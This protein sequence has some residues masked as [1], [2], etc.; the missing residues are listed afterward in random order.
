MAYPVSAGV[1][2]PTAVMGRRIG[3]F[4]IDLVIGLILVLG[5]SRLTVES[6]IFE[7]LNLCEQ[8]GSSELFGGDREDTD[9]TSEICTTDDNRI[10]FVTDNDSQVIDFDD[11]YWLD[12][13]LLLYGIV[14]FVVIQGLTG[15][16]PGKAIVGVRTVN[17]SGGKPGIGRALVRWLMWIVDW[18]P[19]CCVP[20]VG[21]IAAL[22]S[23]GH[24]RVGDMVAKT[25]VIDRKSV[26]S[27][28]LP[29]WTPPGG[30]PPPGAIPGAPPT[31]G[32]APAPGAVTTPAAPTQP[33]AGSTEPTW[34]PQRNQYV[35]FDQ[36]SGRWLAFDD[37]S[38]E[39]KPIE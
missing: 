21:G 24:R 29:D 1:Q 27:P 28:V 17:Q 4:I 9:A 13:A 34:D 3:A 31:P 37:S 19:Y 25:Y 39:W 2:D 20:V 33:A 22:A 30:A 14:V 12:G 38:N 16:T 8:E 23:K 7:D 26:G 36:A 10:V 18:F 11:T 35:Q 5:V 32:A 6:V 15:A